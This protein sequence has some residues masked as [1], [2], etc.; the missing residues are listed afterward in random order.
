MDGETFSDMTREDVDEILL[1]QLLDD[2][3]LIEIG[4]DQIRSEHSSDDEVVDL[5]MTVETIDDGLKIAKKLEAYF[6]E[7]DTESERVRQFQKVLQLCIVN[8]KELHKNLLGLKT[9][10]QRRHTEYILQNKRPLVH[11]S[12]QDNTN[13]DTSSSVIGNGIRSKRQKNDF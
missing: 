1:D 10:K 3:D 9:Y 2:E 6:M 4:E 8:Y 12:T 7:H 13:S 11:Q 5:P